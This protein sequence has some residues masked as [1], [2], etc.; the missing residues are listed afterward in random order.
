MQEVAGSSWETSAQ[1]LV[2]TALLPDYLTADYCHRTRLNKALVRVR[3]QRNWP[4]TTIND[5][6]IATPL[7]LIP[8]L[9]MVGSPNL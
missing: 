4:V 1:V 7:T 8:V 5:S 9:S 2:T 3:C 6:L